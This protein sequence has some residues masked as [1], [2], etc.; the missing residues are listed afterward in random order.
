MPW[1]PELFGAAALQ[2]IEENRRRDKLVTVPFFDG[3]LAGEPD[4]LV[5]SFAGEPEL[6]D[7]VHGRIKGE[8]AFRAFVDRMSAWLVQRNAS[9]EDVGHVVLA[10]HGFEEV[11]IHFD[12]ETGR[13][14]LP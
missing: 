14:D 7:P 9:V 6:Y 13:I 12:G 1:L 2:H 4:A 10:G 8:R 3:L 5:E 11:V